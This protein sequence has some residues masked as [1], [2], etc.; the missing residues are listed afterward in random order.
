MSNA[1]TLYAQEVLSGKIV[2][3]KYVKQACQ[4]HMDDLFREDIFFDAE[5]ADKAITFIERLR[6]TKGQWKGD[7]FILQPWQKFI[8]GNLFG[9]YITGTERRKYRR[10]YIEVPKK[11]GKSPL[12]GAIAVLKF[13]EDRETSPEMFSVATELSQASIAW[14][15]TFNMLEQFTEEYDIEDFV[16]QNSH[17]NKVIKLKQGGYYKPLSF[18]EKAKKDGFSVSMGLVDEYHAHKADSMY[19]ILYD[20]IAARRNPLLL[21]ITTAGDSKLSPCY[22]HR[23][24]CIKVL[25]GAIQD[26][27]LFSVIYTIDMGEDGKYEDWTT[28]EAR[29]KANPNYGISALPEYFESR[30]TEAKESETKKQSYMIKNLNVWQDASVGYIPVEQWDSL[31]IFPDPDISLSPF[32]VGSDLAAVSDW[33]AVCRL[34]KLSKQLYAKFDFYLPEEIVNADRSEFGQIVR[35]WVEKGFVTLTHGNA[36]DYDYIEDDLMKLWDTGNVI[37][38][39]FDPYNASQLNINLQKAGFDEE[40]MTPVR[41]GFTLSTSAKELERIVKTKQIRHDGNPVISWMLSNVRVKIDNKGNYQLTKDN[42]N[43]KIDGII[44]LLNALFLHLEI[45]K[46]DTDE[47]FIVYDLNQL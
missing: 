47:D 32:Y 27:N 39:G 19:N 7:L 43:A 28:L 18:D 10:A 45:Q 6:H 31:R 46:L 13:I 5:K 8:V 16:L 15:Y 21:A 42:E 2:A 33:T 29:Q 22:I 26:D 25:S 4:R 35:G 3:C 14:E 30:L 1:T 20:G 41:Q 38:Y 17:N 11:N 12:A 24:H 37:M 40:K 36:T 34:Y 9:W 44:A 23:N